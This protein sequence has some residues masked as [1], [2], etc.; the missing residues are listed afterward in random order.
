LCHDGVCE[1][2]RTHRRSSVRHALSIHSLPP[3]AT[4]DDVFV[5]EDEFVAVTRV[6]RSA[7][8]FS[9]ATGL[10]I[11]VCS[12]CGPSLESIVGEKEKNV[13]VC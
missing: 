5:K 9:F 12:C 1:R 8:I 7:D 3:A 4:V 6:E 13:V 10:S 2:D 11:A